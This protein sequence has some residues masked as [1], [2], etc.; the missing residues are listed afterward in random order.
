MKN[1]ETLLMRGAIK[2]KDKDG[3][4]GY[5]GAAVVRIFNTKNYNF[6]LNMIQCAVIGLRLR[7]LIK[8][9][10]FLVKLVLEVVVK[11]REFAFLK[12]HQYHTF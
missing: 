5:V 3:Q 10:L 1:P 8:F 7:F 6:M 9:L 11:F 12:C 2:M 4:I